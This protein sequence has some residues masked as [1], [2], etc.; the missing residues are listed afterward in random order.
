VPTARCKKGLSRAE[1][2]LAEFCRR[3]LAG[4]AS[5]GDTLAED[6][7]DAETVIK[8]LNIT[9]LVALMIS[10]GMTVKVQEVAASARHLGLAT[11]GVIANYALI[12]AATV[13]LLTAFQ[14]D[15][16]VSAGFLT[17]AVC[18]GAPLGPA[19]ARIAH[20][21][22]STAT[23]L[24]FILAGLS[25]V[26]SPALL[27]ILLDWVAPT[28]NIVIAFFPILFTLILSQMLP[29]AFGLALHHWRPGLVQTVAKPISFLANFLL[30]ALIATIIFDQYETLAEIGGRAWAGMAALSI[31]S[32]AIGWICCGSDPF[33][34]KS[35]ALTAGTRNVAVG[36]VIVGD[37][38]AKTPAV[39][40]VVAYGLLSTLVA[41]ACSFLLRNVGISNRPAAAA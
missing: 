30:I 22:V 11:L 18:P 6:D 15:P 38:L 16:L 3:V 12:P 35:M 29:L 34:Q 36:L 32:L 14:P 24:M 10:I 28:H 21:D 26:I 2:G 20:G 33:R 7:V 31:G 5:F 40:A 19:F 1:Q 39:T 41:L 25:A 37:S 13:G 4:Q 23:G 8:L 17:L 27:G 9:A